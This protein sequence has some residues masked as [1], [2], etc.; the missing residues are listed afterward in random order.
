MSVGTLYQYFPNR[1][2]LLNAL[3]ADHL[4]HAISAVERAAS[5]SAGMPRHEAAESVVRAFL[6]AKATRVAAARIMNKAFEA[7]LLD[8]RPL[9]AAI[10]HRAH[11]AVAPIAGSFE[12]AQ[13]GCAALEGMVRTAIDD[14]PGKLADPSWVD[15]VVRIATAALAP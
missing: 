12:A 3:L 14:D 4:E 6:T 1:E 11:V 15:Q 2:A 5:A 9:V 13:L 10:V 8:D 7:G